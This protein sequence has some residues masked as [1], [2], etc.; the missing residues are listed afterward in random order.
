M[1]VA[2]NGAGTEA[3][4]AGA[5][6][7][8][9]SRRDLLRGVGVGTGALFLAACSSDGGRA[10]PEAAEDLSD[11]QRTLRFD[12][13][14]TYRNTVGEDFP[15]LEKFG[16][17]SSIDVT[18]TNA[19]SDDNVYYSKVKGQL[20]LGQD[21]G[22]DAVVLSDWMAARWLRLGYV[23]RF[24]HGNIP[25]FESVRPRFK[26]AAFDPGRAASLPWRSG[27]TGLVWDR[28]A[29]PEGLTAV[30]QLW[31]PSL[32]GRVSLMSAMRDTLGSIMMDAG[33]DIESEDWGDAEF[34]AAVDVLR[35]QVSNGQ[36]DSIKGNKYLE[37]L[38][39]GATVA[40]LARAGD[41]MQLNS[42][43]GAD[44]WGFALPESGGVLWS[45]DV[46]I[47]IGS[48]HKTN[49][50]AFVNF[51][52]DPMNAVQVAAATNFISP[53]DIRQLEIDVLDPSIA[54]NRM[55]FPTPVTFERARTFRTLS[56]GEEQRYMAQYQTILLAA[57]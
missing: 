17:L 48:T 7:S 8:A 20:K 52:Y 35:T 49:A 6:R 55:V 21:V 16:S 10:R 15:L 31:D 37:D 40:G 28:E 23:Q 24:D 5:A 1:A 41:V 29:V 12:G 51:Y 38:A 25:N 54:S 56:Q 14:S 13:R 26:D 50:E 2:R 30:S 11:E 22:A 45:D 57:G 18:F 34:A 9:W 33:V 43:A 3:G 32:R 39:S 53:V 47:P 46:V 27:F 44:R 42:E 4:L 36:V 19:V